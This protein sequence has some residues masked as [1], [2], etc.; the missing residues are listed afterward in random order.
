[1]TP[2]ETKIP[3]RANLEKRSPTDIRRAI[4]KLG[5]LTVAE[6]THHYPKLPKWTKDCLVHGK[7]CGHPSHKCKTLIK[8]AQKVR[9]QFKARP[10]GERK[11][12]GKYTSAKP[13]QNKGNSDRSYSKKEVQMLFKR[14]QER[15]KEKE[16]EKFHFEQPEACEA[17]S[18]LNSMNLDDRDTL[19]NELDSFWSE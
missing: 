11:A 12:H 16:A 5:K 4:P 8:H 19:D 3:K 15:D 10:G 2:G 9:G 7:A 1:M 13:W 6:A 14:K 18:M 17:E